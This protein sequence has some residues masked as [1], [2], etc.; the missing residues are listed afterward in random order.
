MAGFQ[1]FTDALSG[2]RRRERQNALSVGAASSRVSIYDRSELLR[3]LAS[4]Q[5]HSPM[6]PDFLRQMLRR[7]REVDTDD[8]SALKSRRDTLSACLSEMSALASEQAD[9]L[10]NAGPFTTLAVVMEAKAKLDAALFL[11]GRVEIALAALPGEQS[12]NS[13]VSWDDALQGWGQRLLL[14]LARVRGEIEALPDDVDVDVEPNAL[15]LLEEVEALQAALADARDCRR[16]LREF[17]PFDG[18]G[19]PKRGVSS[20]AAGRGAEG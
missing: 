8:A 2:K 4:E 9:I 3:R 7:E 19:L 13:L 6:S 17:D 1:R 11:Q 15:R 16:V 5:R 20:F 12:R 18:A 10:E 14:E